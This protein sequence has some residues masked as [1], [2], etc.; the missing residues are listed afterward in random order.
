MNPYVL[1]L[2]SLALALV[3]QS[4][5]A[6]LSVDLFMRPG[7]RRGTRRAWLAVALCALLL[8]VHHGYTIELAVRTG[9]YDLRQAVLAALIAIFFALGVYGL[10]R[11]S[12]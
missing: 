12:A 3:A 1:S 7:Q 8:A 11:S 5:A 2:W 6:G 10:K 4:V 9:L